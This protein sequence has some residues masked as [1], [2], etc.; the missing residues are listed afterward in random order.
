MIA[1]LVLGGGTG[2][3]EI[4]ARALGPSLGQFGVANPLPN[5]TLGLYDSQG[6]LVRG[7]DNWKQTQQA[8]TQ[9]T[10]IPPA[11]DLESALIAILPRV[12]TPRS[13]RG[14]AA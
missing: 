11:N 2:T 6:T 10:G 9:A 5:P 12:T 4:L 7:N 8:E 13:W 1:G 3:N 14:L